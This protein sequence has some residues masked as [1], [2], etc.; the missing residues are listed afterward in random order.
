MIEIVSLLGSM[1]LLR[2]SFLG[3]GAHDTLFFTIVVTIGCFLML[4]HVIELYFHSFFT[5]S[6]LLLATSVLSKQGEC[7]IH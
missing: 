2:A 3:L 4:D 1:L 7:G 5:N 6:F